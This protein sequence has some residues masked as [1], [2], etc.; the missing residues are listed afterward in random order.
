MSSEKISDPES[1]LLDSSVDPDILLDLCCGCVDGVSPC[2]FCSL[3]RKSELNVRKFRQVPGK[4][5]G[6]HTNEEGSCSSM[7][8][9]ATFTSF[10]I[11]GNSSSI[12]L[13]SL[14]DPLVDIAYPPAGL[15]DPLTFSICR[16]GPGNINELWYISA[17]TEAEAC[18]W[19]NVLKAPRPKHGT[20]SCLYHMK[21]QRFLMR[22]TGAL[23]PDLTS[24]LS[25]KQAR[26][27]WAA[28]DRF[29]GFSPKVL[30][31]QFHK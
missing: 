21:V 3:R 6:N 11:H 13:V 17:A 29:A 12:P 1:A 14:L 19:Y 31:L 16:R 23:L 8:C 22:S 2:L 24:E 26:S 28:A 5:Y 18:D 25:I 20:A 10:R 30:L 7:L 27:Y 4:V 15:K 9:E